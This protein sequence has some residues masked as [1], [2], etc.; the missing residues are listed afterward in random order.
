MAFCY[1][2]DNTCLIDFERSPQG[3]RG[4]I[5]KG[6]RV[7]DLGLEQELPIDDFRLTIG[8]PER[9]ASSSYKRQSSSAIGNSLF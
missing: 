1:E 9:P 3:T 7:R 6:L 5:E 2:A 8:R 4:A